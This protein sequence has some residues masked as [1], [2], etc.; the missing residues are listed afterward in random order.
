MGFD[1][2]NKDI[3]ITFQ[4][5]VKPL[6]PGTP[7]ESLHTLTGDPEADAFARSKEGGVEPQALAEKLGDAHSNLLPT[8]QIVIILLTLSL[9]TLVSFMDQT[10]ITVGLS[11]IGK[12]LN[13]QQTINWAGSASLLANTVCQVLF[14]RMS[15]I[16]GRKQ[17]IMTCLMVLV[18][19]DIACSVARTGVEFYIFRAL[20]GIGNGGVSSLLMVILSDIVSLKDRGKYQGILGSS[21]GLGNAI[22]PFIMG[23]FIKQSSWRSYYYFLAPLGFVVNVIF[24]F[25]LKSSKKLNEVVSRKEKFKSIDYFGILVA[26]ASLTL[27]LIPLNG[28]GSTYRWDSNIVIIMFTLGGVLLILFLGVEWKIAKLP[29]IPLRLFKSRSLCLLYLATFCFG[30]AYFSFTYYMP[31]Y[32]QIVKG[33]D[34]IHTSIFF[35]PL[36][37]TQAGGSIVSGQIIT[38]TGHYFYVVTA[39]YVLWLLGCCLLILWK[40]SLN[41]G[42]CVLILLI[43]GTGV[44]CSFQPSM[45]AVQANCM[46]AERAVAISTRN[47]LRSLGGCVGIAAGSTIVSNTVLK[48]LN[49]IDRDNTSLTDSIITYIQGHIY[50]KVDISDLDPLQVS[51]IRDIY[52]MALR[53]YFYFLIPLMAVCVITALFVKDNGLKALDEQDPEQQAKKVK[54]LESSAT[55]M[56]AR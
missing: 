17:V 2:T 46:K 1:K 31:Y 13:A 45:V 28:G 56:T 37:L 4:E 53:N 44:G 43:M 24:Y 33:K 35:L 7:Q 49:G 51:E 5:E 27:L 18:I 39:G 19:G 6:F 20:A 3:T 41:D 30:A 34:E 25:C 40:E 15:D 50:E 9:A 38:R 36:V 26:S 47:V 32:F 8:S 54:D 11:E 23:A 48:E 52:T 29:M 16:F 10:G 21:V 14:G 12:D 42:I 22:G 55:S